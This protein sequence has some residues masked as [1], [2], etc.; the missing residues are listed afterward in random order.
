MTVAI[1]AIVVLASL[2]GICRAGFE[3]SSEGWMT[4]VGWPM[5]DGS[6]GWDFGRGSGGGSGHG[7]GAELMDNSLQEDEMALSAVG[8]ARLLGGGASHAHHLFTDGHKYTISGPTQQ[9]KTIHKVQ[10]H[11][12]G[13][14]VLHRTPHMIQA[15]KKV[16]FVKAEQPQMH[17]W[18]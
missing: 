13:G 12:K 14:D 8:L 1:R 16:I 2:M 4:P 7:G 10:L 6:G 18:H 11:H 3:E 17:G 5:A 15:Q 9:I